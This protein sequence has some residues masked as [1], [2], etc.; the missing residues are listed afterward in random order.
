MLQE[1]S[2]SWDWRTLLAVL[3]W[4]RDSPFAGAES[5]SDASS[6]M[7][8]GSS[9]SS[10]KSHAILEKGAH[11]SWYKAGDSRCVSSQAAREGPA[12]LSTPIG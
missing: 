5:L 11:R 2:R 7:P 4:I 3:D 9:I 10:I 12:S 8:R 1:L 6:R